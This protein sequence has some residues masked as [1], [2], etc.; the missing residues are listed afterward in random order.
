MKNGLWI[1]AILGTVISSAIYMSR[2]EKNN[3]NQS[4]VKKVKNVIDELTK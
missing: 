4:F 3:A 1:G 2:V